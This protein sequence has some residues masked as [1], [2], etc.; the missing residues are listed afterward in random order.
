MFSQFCKWNKGL[1]LPDHPVWLSLLSGAAETQN[2]LP[3]LLN[4]WLYFITFA[5]EQL[6]DSEQNFT[7]KRTLKKI[8]FPHNGIAAPQTAQ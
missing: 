5:V 8:L 1:H 4:S 7:V 3:G 2:N 6:C